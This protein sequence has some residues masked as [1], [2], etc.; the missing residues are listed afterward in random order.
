MMRLSQAARKLN[1]GRN[2]IVE[3]LGDKGFEIDRSPNAKISSE[4]FDMLAK[5]FAASASEKEEA[6][7][8]TI[9][10][11][12]VE[13][14]S[15]KQAETAVE[16]PK[17]DIPEPTPAKTPAPEVVEESIAKEEESKAEEPAPEPVEEEK[18]SGLK[19]VGKID[20]DKGKKKPKPKKEEPVSKSE[21][22]AEEK[23]ES[24]TTE[25]GNV[26]E[27]KADSL[28]GLKVLGK[29]EL[30]KVPIKRKEEEKKKQGGGDNKQKDLVR[31]FKKL[32]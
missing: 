8:L 2:T 4:Q 13:E 23:T 30:P 27:A 3:F 12:H 25:D 19:V 9:G 18:K 20:L 24:V 32:E 28:R 5:E 11:K 10:T 6:S 31:E 7:H 16:E 1:V 14:I 22:A 21:P 29:I 15:S 26:I 17:A